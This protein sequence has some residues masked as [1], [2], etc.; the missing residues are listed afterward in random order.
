MLKG[1]ARS[2]KLIN[3][4]P[5]SKQLHWFHTYQINDLIKHVLTTQKGIVFENKIIY[6]YNT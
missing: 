3:C 4:I 6:I 1:N 2:C 5:K